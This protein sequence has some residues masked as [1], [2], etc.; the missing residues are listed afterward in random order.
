MHPDSRSYYTN[1]GRP[2]NFPSF[3]L[4]EQRQSLMQNDMRVLGAMSTM[5]FHPGGRLLNP[6]R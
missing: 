4:D 2:Y 5:G 3:L 6:R 1:S